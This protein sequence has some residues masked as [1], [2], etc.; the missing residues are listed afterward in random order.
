MKK[1][2]ELHEFYNS[3]AYNSITKRFFNYET[4]GRHR[5]RGGLVLY[6][7]GT[8]RR[9]CISLSSILD[10]I[11]G[12]ITGSKA[13]VYRIT[14]EMVFNGI[15]ETKVVNMRVFLQRLGDDNSVN[16]PLKRFR[17]RVHRVIRAVINYFIDKKQ[18][19]RKV[20]HF[21]PTGESENTLIAFQT[22]SEFMEEKLMDFLENNAKILTHHVRGR[23]KNLQ[24]KASNSRDEHYA[25]ASAKQ[26][27]KYLQA[28]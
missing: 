3:Q 6:A 12:I 23:R 21:R 17:D 16:K 13:E 8:T 26:K 15:M 28:M 22:V 1:N 18:I 2:T 9:L 11:H 19:V 20:G 27:E 4:Q 24:L 10:H 7:D 5:I 25:R 14:E